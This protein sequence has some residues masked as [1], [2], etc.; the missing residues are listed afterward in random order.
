[1]SSETPKLGRTYPHFADED[2]EVKLMEVKQPGQAPLRTGIQIRHL[3]PKTREAEKEASG[4]G[5]ECMLG[6][7]VWRA[8]LDQAANS[9]GVFLLYCP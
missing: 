2:S 4:R 3:D 6:S 7:L 8:R 1:M 9:D 5:F